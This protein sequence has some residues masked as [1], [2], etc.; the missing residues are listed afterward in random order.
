MRPCA[1]L[2]CLVGWS[3]AVPSWVCFHVC[4]RVFA[5]GLSRVSCPG[6]RFLE[7][8]ISRNL[9]HQVLTVFSIKAFDYVWRKSSLDRIGRCE[10]RLH[11]THKRLEPSPAFARI[12]MTD[13]TSGTMLVEIPE[14]LHAGEEMIVIAG[15][16]E[17]SITIPPGCRAGS[18][19][20]VSLP[21]PQPEPDGTFVQQS[22]QYAEVQ[23]PPD[24]QVGD[25]LQVELPQ[26]LIS[27]TVPEGSVPGT[28]IR[29]AL[30]P[31]RGSTP[32]LGRN[33][34]PA[35]GMEDAAMTPPDSAPQSPV[36][37]GSEMPASSFWIGLDVEVLR[38]DGRRTFATIEDI[39]DSSGTYTLSMADGRMKVREHACPKRTWPLGCHVSNR[40]CPSSVADLSLTSPRIVLIPATC[41]PCPTQ[42]MV[43]EEDLRHFRAGKFRTGD[44]VWM[45]VGDRECGARVAGFDDDDET[46]SVRFASGK[47]LDS[48]GYDR[49]RKY[50]A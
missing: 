48:L 40:L 45:R 18:L 44:P 16:H 41:L 1:V 19:I 35:D 12:S 7:L 3:S 28:S 46:Y 36:A 37:A 8:R 6:L 47:V 11:P 15:D 32:E 50:A 23:L 31:E 30:T 4:V 29:I 26:G 38:N 33:G 43:E 13:V 49:I 9:F 20:E 5:T 14:G 39:D 42:Y 2:A 24:C 10:K 34:N 25:E 21:D 17:F 27:F 22:S